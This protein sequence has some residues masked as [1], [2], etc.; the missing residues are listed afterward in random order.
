MRSYTLTWVGFASTPLSFNKRQS[1]LAVLPRV[2]FDSSTT[3]AFNKPRPLTSL[4]SGEFNARTSERNFSPRTSAR[5]DNCSSRRTSSAVVATAHANE[6]LKVF[7]SVK[8]EPNSVE[9]IHYPPNV[10]PCSLGLMQ[11]MTSSSA[12]TADTGYTGDEVFP[13]REY[14]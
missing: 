6:F 3:T 8:A 11:S 9:K 4:T 2:L 14:I 7:R 10:L 13:W 1:C 12:N 5:S